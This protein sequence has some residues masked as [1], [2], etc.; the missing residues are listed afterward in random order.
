MHVRFP[1]E[2][3]FFLAP[4]YRAGGAADAAPDGTSTLGHVVEALGVPLTEVGGL[5]L[6]GADVPFSRI[7]AG[8]G[9]VDVRPV[10]RPQQPDGPLRFL[11]D[12]HFGSLARRLRL[13]GLDTAY[14]NDMD[15]PELVVQANAE[16]RVLLTQDRG[17]LRRKNLWCGA[18]VRGTKADAQLDD[19]L[20]RFA[21]ALRPW[22]RC[23]ACN[24]V[25]EPAAKEDVAG[26]LADGT[27]RTQD[28][29]A[30]CRDCDQVYWRGAH[31]AHLEA[32]VAE[33]ERTVVA[34]RTPEELRG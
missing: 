2:L 24:G 10:A 5:L 8:G 33:A 14:H 17:L 26:R 3:R 21:P 20:R 18:Y 15:D 11:L 13:I 32:V 29:F 34:A 19:V 4:Q 16:H 23:T 6:D 25:L 27:R 28:V 12:V 22:T 9:T 30:R 31:H 1:A 7:P